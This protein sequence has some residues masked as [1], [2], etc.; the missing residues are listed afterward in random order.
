MGK[1]DGGRNKLLKLIAQYTSPQDAHKRIHAGEM[2]SA[3]I[4]ASAV[5]DDASADIVIRISTIQAHLVLQIAATGKTC[6]WGLCGMNQPLTSDLLIAR[7]P[8]A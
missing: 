7:Y 6:R 5:A 2:F 3:G 8:K 4:I 1:W